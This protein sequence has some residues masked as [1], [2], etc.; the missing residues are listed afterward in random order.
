MKKLTRKSVNIDVG[1]DAGVDVGQASSSTEQRLGLFG[2]AVNRRTFLRHSG[3]A[4]GGAALASVAAPTMISKVRA[5]E[6]SPKADVKNRG[7]AIGLHALLCWL[8]C[9]SRGAG[10]SLDGSGT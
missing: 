4:T 5:A 2:K 1:M 8:W 10:R 6:T 3:V 9:R 7:E